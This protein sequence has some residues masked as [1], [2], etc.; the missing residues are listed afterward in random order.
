MELTGED[1][2]LYRNSKLLVPESWL[3]QLCEAWYHLMMHPGA[4]K[5]AH[6]MQGRFRHR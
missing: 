4:K 6:D 3:L 2:K 1:G 5:Q